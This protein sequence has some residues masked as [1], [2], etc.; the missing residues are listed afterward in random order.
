MKVEIL[1][2]KFVGFIALYLRSELQADRSIML[3][4]L[5]Y[6]RNAAGPGKSQGQYL[7]ETVV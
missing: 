4:V 6:F 7:V 2:S 5:I 1:N 3:Q